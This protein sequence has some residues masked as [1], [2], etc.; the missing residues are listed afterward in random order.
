MEADQGSVRKMIARYGVYDSDIGK[1]K[2]YKVVCQVCGK[3]IY[4]SDITPVGMSQNSRGTVNFWH[5]LC[6]E[7]ANAVWNTKIKSNS[8]IS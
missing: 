3:P 7:N 5:G 8:G 2:I 1:K 6:A 4:S